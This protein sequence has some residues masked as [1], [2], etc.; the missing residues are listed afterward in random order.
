MDVAGHQTALKALWFLGFWTISDFVRKE[1]W[2]RLSDTDRTN[3]L[4]EIIVYADSIPEELL[5]APLD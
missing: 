2:L 5:E 4:S 1:K 3:I